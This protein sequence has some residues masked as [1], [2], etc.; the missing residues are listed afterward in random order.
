[1]KKAL[2]VTFLAACTSAAAG[3]L[4]WMLPTFLLRYEITGGTIED[5]DPDEDIMIPSSLRNAASL[6]IRE[7]ADPLSL[8]LLI[9]YS[10][11]DYLLQT[12]DY[13][14]LSLDPE[15][16]LKL[17]EALT[18]GASSGF[19]WASSPEPDSSGLSKDYLALKGGMDA[20]WKPLKGTALDISASAEYDLYDASEKAR[21]LYSVSAGLSSRLGEIV[22]NVRYRGTFRMPLGDAVLVDQTALNTASVSLQWDPNR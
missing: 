17:S 8:G 15:A 6:T 2:I 9:R 7:D 11:K 19:K 10:A 14:Y 18:L 13:S 1:M 20:T 5:A 3:A 16:K 21:Q 4:D 22:L 12:G